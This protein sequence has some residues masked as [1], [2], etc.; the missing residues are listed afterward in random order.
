MSKKKRTPKQH[1][2]QA[3]EAGKLGGAPRKKD[4]LRSVIR[5][6]L[7]DLFLKGSFGSVTEVQAQV[8]A[9]GYHD[10]TLPVQVSQVRNQLLNRLGIERKSRRGALT[11]EEKA[12]I[13][14][15]LKMRK[16]EVLALK[17]SE[18]AAV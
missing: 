16:K 6:V 11:N 8:G 9:A 10:L 5:E 14:V 2:A 13:V 12:D 7:L 18:L 1:A 4:S 3:R 17:K 15:Q